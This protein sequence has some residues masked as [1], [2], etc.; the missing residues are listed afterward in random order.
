LSEQL[1]KLQS[2]TVT[3]VVAS[4]P[5]LMGILALFGVA[6]IFL[7]RFFPEAVQVEWVVSGQVIQLLTVVT[8][9]LIILCLAL[10]SII[11]EE[12]IGT[13]LGGI[14]GY[15][16]SQ[17]IGRAAGRAAARAANPG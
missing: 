14:G 11:K 10:T 3:S 12:T 8:L 5:W 17:G 4:L 1:R 13:L 2:A 9:L 15:V 16:L 7:V 6:A